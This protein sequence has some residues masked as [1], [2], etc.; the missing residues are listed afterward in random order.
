[1]Y[2]H[3]LTVV[4]ITILFLGLSIQPSIA[5]K[6]I[7]SDNED[8]CSICPKISKLKE[9]GKYQELFDRTTT[10]KEMN[11]ELKSDSDRP[12]ICAILDFLLIPMDILYELI[13]LL[14]DFTLI[15]LSLA[16][17]ILIGIISWSVILL[18]AYGFDCF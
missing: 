16:S 8:D 2:K 10:L 11:K 17:I 14:Q 5:V 12:I 7:S 15:S 9:L 18:I 13:N 6:P 3:I 4:G 1:M